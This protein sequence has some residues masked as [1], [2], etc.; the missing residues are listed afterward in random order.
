MNTKNDALPGWIAAA[1]ILGLISVGIGAIASHALTDPLAVAALEKAALYQMIHAVV[2]LF[3]SQLNGRIA[4]VARWLFFI[5]I[6]LF[7]GSIE[8]KYLF[9][10]QSATVVAPTGG[11][12]LML[13]WVAL[14]VAGF[15]QRGAM[16][17]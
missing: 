10:Q 8:L 2:L 3:V 1:A 11:I 7:S 15:R 9:A 17:R 16:E 13:G 12:C 5:G 14:G 6:I 4:Q